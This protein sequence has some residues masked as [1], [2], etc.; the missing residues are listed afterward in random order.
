M[1][2]KLNFNNKPKLNH[3]TKLPKQ[4]RKTKSTFLLNDYTYLDLDTLDLNISPWNNYFKDDD[5]D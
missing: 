5:F 3:T 1:K 4:I 2:T